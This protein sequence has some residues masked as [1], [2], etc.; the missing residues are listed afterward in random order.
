MSFNMSS[1]S[2]T[3]ITR[4]NVTRK[5]ATPDQVKAY[6]SQK[7]AFEAVLEEAIGALNHYMHVKTCPHP[8]H[9]IGEVRLAKEAA[10]AQLARAVTVFGAMPDDDDIIIEPS[11]ESAGKQLAA[12]LAAMPGVQASEPE[13]VDGVTHQ[14]FTIDAKAFLAGRED[15]NKK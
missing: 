8:E 6:A 12:L 7:A 4:R 10:V 14:I 3:T 5:N 13:E 2:K 9:V 1:S 11:R 15:S